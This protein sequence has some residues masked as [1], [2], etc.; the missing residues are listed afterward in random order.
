MAMMKRPQKA[1]SL[2]KID[3]NSE[4]LDLIVR[5]WTVDP[6]Q[7]ISIEEIK[8]HNWFKNNIASD[9]EVQAFIKTDY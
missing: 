6:D 4:A 2:R 7:R 8:T 3:I 9:Y 5:M 1:M